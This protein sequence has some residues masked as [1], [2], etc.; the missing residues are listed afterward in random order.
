MSGVLLT[1]GY[2]RAWHS[3]YVAESLRRLGHAPK[4]IL[5]AYPMSRAR[6]RTILRSRGWRVA[7]AYLGRRDL[8]KTDSPM[9]AAVRALGIQK[10]SLRAWARRHGVP[11]VLVGNLN[12][13]RAVRA[14]EELG[15][16]VT[17]YTGGGILRSAFL[18]ACGY[19]VLNCHSG[20]LPAVRGMNA[21]EWSLLLGQ[22]TGVTV[23]LIDEGIDTGPVLEWVEVEPVRGDTLDSLRERLVLAGA[24]SMVRWVLRALDGAL[25]TPAPPAGPRQRQCFVVAPA[26]REL[27]ALRLAQRLAPAAATEE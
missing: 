1:A 6:I 2:D 16:Q 22:P 9:R 26:L 10:P 4:L 13:E 8:A 14:A 23:H 3:V 21:L 18:R 25:Q 20:P 15:P 19:R 12:N 24:E 27:A 5:V 7:L 17:A 11:L